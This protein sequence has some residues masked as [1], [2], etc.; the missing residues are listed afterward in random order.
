MVSCLAM[1]TAWQTLCPTQ[2]ECPRLR[3]LHLKIQ[4][5]MA[6][7]P[8]V[9]VRCTAWALVPTSQ[10][11]VDGQFSAAP[12]AEHGSCIPLVPWPDVRGML[13]KGVVAANAGVVL[14]AALVLDSDDVPVRVPVGTLCGGSDVD[15]VDCWRL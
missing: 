10:V 15:A 4:L 2:I 1:W 9:E 11:F 13:G 8:G 3:Y 12:P 14:S 7:T 6:G 5:M